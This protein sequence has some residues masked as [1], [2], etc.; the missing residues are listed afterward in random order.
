MCKKMGAAMPAMNNV[1][2]GML[3][4][5]T[6]GAAASNVVVNSIT[7]TVFKSK[8]VEEKGK[9]A[10]YAKLALGAAGVLCA[11]NSYLQAASL[12][13]LID[14]GVDVL[15][16][17]VPQL[18]TFAA[19]KEPVGGIGEVIDLGQEDWSLAGI[20]SDYAVGNHQGYAVHGAGGV[21]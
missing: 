5:T 14:G 12:G 2:W 9:I 7:N 16:A 21:N 18:K 4:A 13:I 19:L 11:P 6:L 1:D 17:N 10:G 8:T 20:E 3:A 15:R